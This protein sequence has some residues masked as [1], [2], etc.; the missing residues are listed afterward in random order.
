M[1]QE[2]PPGALGA[3]YQ[4]VSKGLGVP[5]PS[6]RRKHEET[7]VLVSYHEVIIGNY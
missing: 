3:V 4:R 7:G 2:N 6:G 1:D 5:I